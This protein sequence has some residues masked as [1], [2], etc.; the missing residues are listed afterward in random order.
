M[1]MLIPLK[2]PAEPE[3]EF[4]PA[5]PLGSLPRAEMRR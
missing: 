5:E 1:P 4:E 2:T 3:P